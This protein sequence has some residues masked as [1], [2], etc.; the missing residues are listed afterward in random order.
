MKIAELD[1]LS[2]EERRAYWGS[3]SDMDK[4]ILWSDIL[5]YEKRKRLKRKIRQRLPMILIIIFQFLIVYY[6]SMKGYFGGLFQ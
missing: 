6:L 1:K 3:L 5:R 2:R 4:G